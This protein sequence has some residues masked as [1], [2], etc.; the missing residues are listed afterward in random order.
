MLIR[1]GYPSRP[2]S[3]IPRQASRFKC[4]VCF[5]R[6]VTRHAHHTTPTSRHPL[7]SPT[8]RLTNGYQRN[9]DHHH[10]TAV[11]GRCKTRHNQGRQKQHWTGTG[12][13]PSYPSPI[14]YLVCFSKIYYVGLTPQN[15]CRCPS[16]CWWCAKK[17][18]PTLTWLGGD[19]ARY[20]YL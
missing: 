7:L 14:P 18:S 12:D 3:T 9:D 6:L 10:S 20:L 5:N 11:T 15:S 2:S 17:V 16:P 13:G 4:G 8:T 19:A 1:I